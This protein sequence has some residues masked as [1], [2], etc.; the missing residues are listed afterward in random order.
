MITPSHNERVSTPKS[1]TGPTQLRPTQSVPVRRE[2]LPKEAAHDGN[3][4]ITG[5]WTEA[6]LTRPF[7]D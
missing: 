6:S 3:E 4:G 1:M 2:T 5:S 7:A